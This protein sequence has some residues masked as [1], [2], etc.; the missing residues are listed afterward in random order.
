MCSG[1]RR[2]R[3]RRARAVVEVVTDYLEGTLDAETRRRFT[4]HLELC[5]GCDAY[6]EQMRET[7]RLAG[8]PREDDLHPDV[9]DKL[10]AAFWGWKAGTTPS[11]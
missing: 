10:L 4:E 9:R 8:A 3:G 6:V 7:A 2:W 5:A 1:G 11:P